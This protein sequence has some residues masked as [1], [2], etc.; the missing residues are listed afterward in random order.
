LVGFTD[1]EG[2]ITSKIW[3][4]GGSTA[5]GVGAFVFLGGAVFVILIFLRGGVG[6]DAFSFEGGGA[7]LRFFCGTASPK[8][9]QM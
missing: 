7:R 5:F 6:V 8:K 3:G 9:L 1:L 2:I 4:G